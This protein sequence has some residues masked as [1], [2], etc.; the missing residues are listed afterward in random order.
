MYRF[1]TGLMVVLLGVTLIG[2]WPSFFSKLTEAPFTHLFHGFT[3]TVWIVIL[4]A[5]AWLINA[6]KP[7]AH[8]ML[9][10]T[11]LL[12]APFMVAGFALINLDSAIRAAQGASM[13]AQLFS[14]PLMIFDLIFLPLTL[15]LIYLGLKHRKQSRH[16]AAFMVLTCFA[17]IGPSLSRLLVNFVP[18]FQVTGPQSMSNFGH[19]LWFSMLLTILGIAVIAVNVAI[20]RKVWLSAL[21]IYV[22][23]FLL[24]LTFGTTEIWKAFVVSLSTLHYGVV[25]WVVL[26]LS[27]AVIGLGWQQGKAIAKP[28]VTATYSL[29][30]S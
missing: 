28:G 13:F 12:L 27:F 5:Q 3:S 23:S 10:I 2:F 22:V 15:G 4:G 6:R 8:K 19:A 9:G 30:R 11:G 20:E 26:A 29:K 17:L 1:T 18:G 16:H 14:A 7:V 24:Y 25:F 21:T